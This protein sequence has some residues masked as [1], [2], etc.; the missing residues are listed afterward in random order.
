MSSPPANLCASTGPK[1]HQAQ[2]EALDLRS[3]LEGLESLLAKTKQTLAAANGRILEKD[4]QIAKVSPAIRV[5]DRR[6]D[7]SMLRLIR[8]RIPMGDDWPMAR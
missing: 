2:Q 6:T 1:R 8:R 3:K 7:Q 4:R 5:A